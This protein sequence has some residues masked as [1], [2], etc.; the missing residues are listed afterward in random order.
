MSQDEDYR[1]PGDS[2]DVWEQTSKWRPVQLEMLKLQLIDGNENDIVGTIDMLGVQLY[3]DAPRLLLP[4]D[5]VRNSSSVQ[6]ISREQRTFFNRLLQLTIF[7]DEPPVDAVTSDLLTYS[8]F[9]SENIHFR[10]RPRLRF[11]CLLHNVTSIPDY[12]VFI[13]RPSGPPAYEYLVV[14]ENKAPSTCDTQYK[15]C[16]LCGEMLASAISRYGERRSDKLMFGALVSG[17]EVRFY[18][19]TFSR[20]YLDSIFTDRAPYNFS[21]VARFPSA[22]EYALSLNKRDTREKIVRILHAIRLQLEQVIIDK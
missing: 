6:H 17:L 20:S 8:G 3:E 14:V 15:E 9:E 2:S 7:N 12:G 22:E 19:T 5:D 4:C 18:K 11:T 13:D 10:P 1:P 21:E 16:Q